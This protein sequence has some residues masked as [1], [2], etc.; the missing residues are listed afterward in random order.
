MI[1]VSGWIRVDAANRA[2]YLASCRDVV[3]AARSAPGCVDFCIS[4]D[5]V[6]PGRINVY[7]QWESVDS[8]EAFRGSGPDDGQQTMILDAHVAQHEV[9][10]SLELT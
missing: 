4:A 3:E 10:S 9:A 2:E 6:D 1:I 5:L 8:V 7:E